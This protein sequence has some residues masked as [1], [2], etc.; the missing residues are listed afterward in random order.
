MGKLQDLVRIRKRLGDTLLLHAPLSPSNQL[1]ALSLYTEMAIELS[2]GFLIRIKGEQWGLVLPHLINVLHCDVRFTDWLPIVDENR[3]FLVNRVHLQKQLT[4]VPQILFSVL[5][6][7]LLLSQSNSYPHPKHARPEI[8][9]YH[10]ITHFPNPK[11]RELFSFSG[12]QKKLKN[13]G[14]K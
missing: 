7:D 10:F 5:I 8:Q 14:Y 1:G 12:V 3:D 11:K 9:Q 13:N 2:L 6:L 4:L